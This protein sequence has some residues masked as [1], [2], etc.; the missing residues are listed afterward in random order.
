MRVILSGEI[1]APL[2]A[3]INP[4]G[5]FEFPKL[6][7]GRYVLRIASKGAETAAFQGPPTASDTTINVTS[8]D[9]TGVEIVW[10][11]Q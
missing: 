3:L 5:S 10:R 8:K 11:R 2:A 9:V 7:Q 1:I 4:D 6:T